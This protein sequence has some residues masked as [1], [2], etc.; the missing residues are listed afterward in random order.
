MTAPSAPAAAPA[1]LITIDTEGDAAWHQPRVT[2]TRNARFL[3]RFQ[4]LCERHGFQ[5]TYLTNH[6]MVCDA[7]MQDLG[8][9]VIARGTG[10]IGMHLHAWNS[11]PLVPLTNDDLRHQPFLIEYP[12]EVLERKVVEL[13][14]RLEQ[15]F[16]T[17]MVSHRAGRWSFDARYA[18]TLVRLGYT[19][20][21]S[22]TPGVSWRD[23]P[24]DP[25]QSG[26][27]DYRAFPRGAYYMDLEAID[28]PGASPLLELPM[29]IRP[30]WRGGLPWLPGV[31]ESLPVIG[32]KLRTQRW[33]R[34]RRGGN[35]AQ[36]RALVDEARAERAPYIEFM[37]HSS[38][39]MPG[40]SPNFVTEADIDALYA[41]L[42]ALF[43]DIAHDHVGCT[44]GDYAAQV[45][46]GQRPVEGR[47]TA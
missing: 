9:D 5:P 23:T 28:R 41:E 47:L 13:T 43:A 10:E 21:C 1:F 44:L 24:G 22:V 34:P 2:E 39:F 45:R 38:E 12:T 25:A 30:G 36:M 4:A 42:E 20:D 29:T 35:L 27:T 33:L 37:L 14:D 26:G 15:T 8:R 31:C 17:K 11:P 6:E 7:A 46:A 18:R 16:A 19:V 32:R 40:G 3:P